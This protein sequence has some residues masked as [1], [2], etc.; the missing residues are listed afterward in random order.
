MGTMSGVLAVAC[1][2]GTALARDSSDTY[3]VASLDGSVAVTVDLD[4]AA[5]VSMSVATESGDH[6]LWA[7]NA[8]AAI[9]G[10]RCV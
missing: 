1:L 6:T 4:S 5:V 7:V 8:V 3:T 2:W 9:D 10:A